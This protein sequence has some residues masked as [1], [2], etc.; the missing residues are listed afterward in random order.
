MVILQITF[1]YFGAKGD[2]FVSS[3]LD[4]AKSINKET[5]FISKIWTFNDDYS[6]AGGVYLFDT[7]ENAQN[8]ALMHS[9]RL[10][11]YK[12]A[13]NIS[14]EILNVCEELSLINNFKHN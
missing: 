10:S 7:K 13:S 1:D 6:R 5:G 4:L 14:Y 2:E 3:C 8:Y 9:N 12:I 11:E